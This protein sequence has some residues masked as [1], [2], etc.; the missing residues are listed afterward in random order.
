MIS[1]DALPV[2]PGM[3]F[4]GDG[5]DNL[6]APSAELVGRLAHA[7]METSTLWHRI[8]QLPDADGSS[9][10]A[11]TFH[12]SEIGVEGLVPA[13]LVTRAA[14]GLSSFS[15]STDLQAHSLDNTAPWVTQEGDIVTALGAWLMLPVPGA[16]VSE[17]TRTTTQ[18]WY[19]LPLKVSGEVASIR[20]Q[21]GELLL[22]G[23]DF[24]H[25][26]DLLFFQEH[27]SSMF[28]GGAFWCVLFVADVSPTASVNGVDAPAAAG[29]ALAVL[30][31]EVPTTERIEHAVNA[32]L[33]VV[34]LPRAGVLHEVTALPEGFRYGFD[35]GDV[36]CAYEH[37]ALDAGRYYAAGTQVGAPVRLY[38]RGS[39]SA[40]WWR[41]LDWTWPV[42]LQWLCPATKNLAVSNRTVRAE[43][44]AVA[45]DT[46]VKLYIDGAPEDLQKYWGWCAQAEKTAGRQRLA[47]RLSLGVGDS[48]EIDMLALLFELAGSR[49]V[50]V[51]ITTNAAEYTWDVLRRY[52]PSTAVFL[53]R[54][55][56]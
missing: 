32:A 12:P 16:M 9:M 47:T 29:G 8:T 7:S 31:R 20:T 36:L 1:L 50:V 51:D 14:D 2:S 11:V 21:A 52:A 37:T 41:A 26:F 38:T 40:D 23:V 45:G 4:S 18:T 15:S 44:Y 6:T 49:A 33:G 42:S 34:A 27:P 46:C 55:L 10:R 54:F 39:Q 48:T 22:A 3:R 13:R 56:H 25:A 17:R 43:G 53:P 30:L 35:W 5:W 19:T 24:V 28:P